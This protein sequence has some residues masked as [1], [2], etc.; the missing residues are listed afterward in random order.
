M[1]Q[2]ASH[3]TVS[4][5]RSASS[6]IARKKHVQAVSDGR[7][8]A[9]EVLLLLEQGAQVQAALDA[10]LRGAS[11]KPQDRALCTELV[12]GFLRAELRLDFILHSL[13]RNPRKLPREMYL[14]MGLAVYALL[15]LER[16]PVHATVNWTVGQVR[17]RFGE[18]MS[19]VANGALRAFVRQGE[20]PKD[21]AY[22]LPQNQKADSAPAQLQR[23]SLFYS[24]PLW[25]VRLWRSAYGAAVCQALLQRSL[26]A[27][28]SCV[29]INARSPHA[30]E[31]RLA[32]T[33]APKESACT[34]SASENCTEQEVAVHHK[35][36]QGILV[37]SWGVAFAPGASPRSVANAPL[38]YWQQQGDISFQSAGSQS[39]MNALQAHTWPQ[40]VWDMCAG[41]GGKS[42]LLY[43]QGIDLALCTDVHLPRLESF[44]GN[45]QRIASAFDSQMDESES[46]MGSDATASRQQARDCIDAM[47]GVVGEHIHC[48]PYLPIK[49]AKKSRKQDDADTDDFAV[50]SQ[51]YE[52]DSNDSAASFEVALPLVALANGCYAPKN[53]WKGTILIDA[54]CSGLGVLSRRPDI[55]RV[56]TEHSLAELLE[57]QAQLLEAG[58]QSLHAGSALVYMTCTLNPAEN[59]SQIAILQKNHPEV[60]IVQQWQ[61]PHEHPWLEGMFAV[62]CVKPA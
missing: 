31:L 48:V 29:R 54:P 37:G 34:E 36:V 25:I 41:Q 55:R 52:A 38:S 9:L 5:V 8:A 19:R 11:L 30:E 59:E 43:E 47:Q 40:P 16:I 22:Y 17:H 18:A 50:Y 12:Y 35:H 45:M 56:R 27:P 32:L 6:K 33:A 26:V 61:T 2:V 13:L 10:Y 23:D 15:F 21:A 42:C 44:T 3:P 58:W 62:C 39:A 20:A 4:S 53:S 7:R 46:A 24:V 14:A 1:N 60:Q 28:Y 49:N 51:D 57:L